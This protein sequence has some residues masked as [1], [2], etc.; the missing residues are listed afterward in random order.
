MSADRTHLLLVDPDEKGRRLLELSLKKDGYRVTAVAGTVDALATMHQDRASIVL[1]EVALA[2]GDGATLME[3]LREDEGTASVPIVVVTDSSDASA[4]ARCIELGAAEIVT[5][6][7]RVKDVLG[8]VATLLK[9]AEEERMADGTPVV[10][11][12]LSDTTVVDL[13]NEFRAASRSGALRIDRGEMRGTIWFENGD[14]VDAESVRDSGQRALGRMFAWDEG[15]Y[16][17]VTV[18]SADHER[19]LHEDFDALVE[20]AMAYAADWADAVQQVGSLHAVYSVEYRSFVSQLGKLPEE[21]NALIRTF[22]GIRTVEEAI[23]KSD[24]D[25]L[26]ALQLIAPLVEAEVLQLVRSAPTITANEDGFE[27]LKT[28]AF[29]PIARTAEQEAAAQRRRAEEEARKAEEEARKKAEEERQRQLVELQKIEA[30]EAEL[31]AQRRAEIDAAEAEAA[32]LRAEADA[33]AEALRE[34]AE[35]RAAA[36]RDQKAELEERRFHLTGQL[37][38]IPA[39]E[40]DVPADVAAMRR[41]ERAAL[42]REKSGTLA[43]G[44]AAIAAARAASAPSPAAT[45]SP[46]PDAAPAP[47]P[48]APDATVAFSPDVA[49]AVEAETASIE[50]SAAPSAPDATVAFSPDV[51]AAVDAA[52][53]DAAP[54]ASGGADAAPASDVALADDFFGSVPE[55]YDDDLFAEPA[56]NSD[57][58]GMMAGAAFAFAVLL[59]ILLWLSLGSAEDPAQEI[60]SDAEVEEPAMAEGSALAEGSATGPSP[61]EVA[62]ALLAEQQADVRDKAMNLG[63]DTAYRAEDVIEEVEVQDVE[64][65]YNP[66]AVAASTPPRSRPSRPA[67]NDDDEPAPR[68]SAATDTSG[69][70]DAAT[71]CAN[72]YNGGN[73]TEAINLCEA[74]ARLNARDSNV[75]T[76]LGNAHFEVGNDGQAGTYLERAVQLNRRN[77]NA[78]LTL[79]ALKQANGDVV[80]ARE[81]YE[82]YLQYNPNS[83]RAT[84]IRRILEQEL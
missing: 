13:V 50:P 54:D 71:A 74:A 44:G 31:E 58:T 82:T 41:K 25:D 48:S 20:S 59:L 9:H 45:P 77:S 63:E 53:E 64:P 68:R 38:A 21:A 47:A 11:G 4:K 72:A 19:R 84:E 6:P 2:D 65:A 81:V 3:Q 36:L 7:V 79:G 18:E 43:L 37:S 32:R 34:E 83:R 24:V 62:A 49:A 23:A 27:R 1:T 26:A 16:T 42:E 28:N 75:Y 76:Y 80:G 46:Q 14:I 70:D 33:A 69:A 66:P 8:R 40:E 57:R 35:S 67:S 39:K 30:E 61:Q 12:D 73:Y 52:T 55:A 15:S 78:L 5:K 60:A 29:K 51:A 22:D 56:D 10:S 17:V